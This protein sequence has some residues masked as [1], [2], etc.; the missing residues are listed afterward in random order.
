[1]S[2]LTCLTARSRP[3]RVFMLVLLSALDSLHG[4][5]LAGLSDPTQV[6][7]S[8]SL[9]KVSIGGLMTNEK[10]QQ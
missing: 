10:Q 3:T 1:M 9:R 4:G 2:E 7:S 5:Y 6:G 8:H